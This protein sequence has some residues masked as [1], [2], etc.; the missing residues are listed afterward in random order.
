MPYGEWQLLYHRVLASYVPQG[1][2]MP[3]HEV[4][5]CGDAICHAD[6]GVDCE[7][8]F[9]RNQFR[10]PASYNQAAGV[11]QCRFDSNTSVI[12]SRI[13]EWTDS[14]LRAPSPYYERSS[15]V[16]AGNSATPTL[17]CSQLTGRAIVSAASCK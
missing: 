6:I 5:T 10:S 8:N 12:I 1:A 3:G 15:G 14:G 13:A 17:T 11:I 4:M 2:V 9:V 16:T 7:I